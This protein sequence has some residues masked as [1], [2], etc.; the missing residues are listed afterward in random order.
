MDK[1]GTML[2]HICCGPCATHCAEFWQ[3][4]GYEVI[5]FWYNPNI[6]PYLEHQKRLEAVQTF[7]DK[8]NLNLIIYPEYEM[9]LY[10][11]T[12]AGHKDER[13]GF[14]FQMRL[15]RTAQEAAQRGITDFSTTLLIS[16]Y[17]K[18]QLLS[19][20]GLKV[21][22]ETGVRFLYHDL[23]SGFSHSRHLSKELELYRQQYCGCIYSEWERYRNIRQK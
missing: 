4:E 8:K 7:A 9:P 11:R 3:K 23:R 20:I 16:P 19:E 13:C 17:Q 10:L 15:Y 21:Q 2:L 5:L 12:V 22:N 14:C 6:H 1:K 18:H